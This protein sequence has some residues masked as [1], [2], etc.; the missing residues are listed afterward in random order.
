MSRDELIKLI[1]SEV[2]HWDNEQVALRHVTGM[3]PSKR[4]AN[5]DYAKGRKAEAIKI[6]GWL[7]VKPEARSEL[8]VSA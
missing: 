1:Q 8:K 3:L 7:G 6:L 2:R 4:N 5:I